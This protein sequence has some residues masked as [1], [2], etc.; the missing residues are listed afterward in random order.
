[1]RDSTKRIVV[2]VLFLAV[3]QGRASDVNGLE[4]HYMAAFQYS[5]IAGF[6]DAVGHGDNSLVIDVKAFWAG[7]Y[8]TNPITINSAFDAWTDDMLAG[9]PDYFSGKRIVFFAVTNEWKTTVP[10]RQLTDGVILD[11]SVVVTNIGAVCAPKFVMGDP[12]TWFALDTNDVEHLAFYSNIVKSIVVTRD[13]G[14]LYTT[15]R[16]VIK[17]DASVVQPYRAMSFMPMWKL[18]WTA[19]EA[20]LVAALN[21]PL[22]APRLRARALAHLKTKFGWPE[23]ST[24]PEP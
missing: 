5:D 8:P 3:M 2:C 6:G 23:E 22:L 16:N 20:E 15:L 11:D 18:L 19:S 10:P 9:L 14:L 12:P 21:D 17:S 24:I 13:R 1:M 7:S 4:T